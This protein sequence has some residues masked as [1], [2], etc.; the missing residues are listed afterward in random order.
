MKRFVFWTLLTWSMLA[1]ALAADDKAI[2]E[3]IYRI[4]LG[5]ADDVALLLKQGVSPDQVDQKGAPLLAVAA[6]RKDAEGIEMMKVLLD[7]GADINA[8]DLDGQNALFY[9]A[10]QGNKN[11]VLFLMEKNINYYA[12][13]KKG[14]IARTI[15]H[16]E[17]HA[18]IVAAMDKFVADQTV[19][20]TEQYKEYNKTVEENYKKIQEQ[21]KQSLQG[22]EE[23]KKPEAPKVQETPKAEESLPP[24]HANDVEADEEGFDSSYDS[25]Y[26]SDS[27]D[28]D[29]PAGPEAIEAK[30]ATPAFREDMRKLA[31]ESCAF[32]YWSFCRQVEQTTDLS[33]S[34]L[35]GAIDAHRQQIIDTREHVIKEY[36]VPETYADRVTDVAKKDMIRQLSDM[37]SKTYRFEHGVCKMAD[38]NTRC[39]DV[40]DVW[41]QEKPRK[42]RKGD[43]AKGGGKTFQGGIH[44]TGKSGA[45][46]IGAPPKQ[47]KARSGGGK[48]HAKKGSGKHG[49]KKTGKKN[50]SD[51]S[52]NGKIIP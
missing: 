24:E 17:G 41:D 20:V 42:R 52:N 19:K 51:Q 36:E 7:G 28:D 47:A 13:D 6:T 48:K 31:F 3:T 4:N 43:D 49:A 21:D 29:L 45:H 27:A 2:R 40:A 50:Q 14:D 32:Q 33:K 15:A 30:R 9:A 23:I 44:Q 39:S 12:T 1:P 18:D 22:Q 11:A 35:N 38:L 37:P 26:D 8:T 46:G 16:R 5:R 10:R 25:S 34:Q